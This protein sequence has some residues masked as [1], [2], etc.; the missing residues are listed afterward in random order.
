MAGHGHV[1]QVVALQVDLRRAARAFQDHHVVLRG[2][3]V[4]GVVDHA[5]QLSLARM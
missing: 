3:A 1:H 4:I 5:A 2:Q